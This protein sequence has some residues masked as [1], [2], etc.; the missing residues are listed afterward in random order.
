MV[1]RVKK[2]AW[3]WR[4]DAVSIGFPGMVIHGRPVAEPYNLGKGW[5]GFD[6]RAAFGKPVKVINDAAMQAL[7]S[8]QG[9]KMLFLGLGTGFGATVIMDDQSDSARERHSPRRALERLGYLTYTRRRI[10]LPIRTQ[11]VANIA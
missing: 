11:N 8:Y 7:G 5:V 4:Y 10:H 6:F 1:A 2:L 9:G 3:G